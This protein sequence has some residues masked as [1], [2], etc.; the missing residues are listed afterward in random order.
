MAKNKAELQTE[1]TALGEALSV[2]VV[3]DQEN[4]DLIENIEELNQ[5]LAAS[6]GLEDGNK[7]PTTTSDE[8]TDSEL[9][10]Q[11]QAT[12]T[13]ETRLKNGEKLFLL[14]GQ[15]ADVDVALA[16]ILIDE[17]VALEVTE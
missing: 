5:R 17:N 1:L 10:I 16:E 13:F 8:N 15:C 4:K 7:E 14:K 2:P 12:K 6:Q 9:I 11:I 3:L